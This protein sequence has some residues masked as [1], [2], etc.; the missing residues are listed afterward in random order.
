MLAIAHEWCYRMRKKC[1]LY[2]EDSAWWPFIHDAR[3]QLSQWVDVFLAGW[4]CFEP[5][6]CISLDLI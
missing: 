3:T 4:H 6:K 2:Q 1:R 5:L